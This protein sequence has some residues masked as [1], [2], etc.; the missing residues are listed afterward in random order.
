MQER[1]GRTTAG[2]RTMR[3]V[4]QDAYGRAEV[5][6]PRDVPVPGIAANEVL[7][8]VRAAGLDRGVWHTMTGL[9]YLGRLAFGL[10]EPRN[11]VPGMDVAG[12]VVAVGADVS[13]FA[14]GDEVLGVGRGT[15]A[16]YAAATE[17]ALVHK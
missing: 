6:H 15:F 4:V 11:P 17:G 10:R 7:V 5:L 12:V 13:R 8:Q 14:V 16:E 2:T 9:P 3:A 1:L